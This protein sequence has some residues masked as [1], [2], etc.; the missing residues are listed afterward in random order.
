MHFCLVNCIEMQQ[1]LRERFFA[2]RIDFMRERLKCFLVDV[3]HLHFYV[4]NVLQCVL[5]CERFCA[6]YGQI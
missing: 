3:K 5:R 6:R 4:V 2:L 1:S